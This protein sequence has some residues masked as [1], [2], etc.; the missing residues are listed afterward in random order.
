MTKRKT[1]GPKGYTPL[2]ERGINRGMSQIKKSVPD[3]KSKPK[4]PKTPKSKPFTNPIK[5]AI[6]KIPS[7]LQKVGK[8]LTTSVDKT[9]NMKKAES[10]TILHFF[11]FI[12]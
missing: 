11:C 7:K 10:I 5:T 9:K 12:F 3:T 8:A 4:I 1:G 2:Y 6:N